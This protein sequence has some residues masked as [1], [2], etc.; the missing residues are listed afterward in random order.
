MGKQLYN[1]YQP[2]DELLAGRNL[3]LS[4][5]TEPLIEHIKRLA[6]NGTATAKNY[7]NMRGWAVHH[8]SDIWAQTNPVG[9]GMVILNGPTGVLAVPG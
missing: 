4:E 7:Y 1:Q 8:N 2:A 6:K 9:E 3:N 5:M